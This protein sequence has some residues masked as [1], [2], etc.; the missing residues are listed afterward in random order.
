MYNV[1]MYNLL[2]YGNCGFSSHQQYN[3]FPFTLMKEYEGE[4]HSF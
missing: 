1:C 2:T 3:Y 4:L